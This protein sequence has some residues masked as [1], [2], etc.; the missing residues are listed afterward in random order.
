M[1]SNLLKASRDNES[2]CVILY[3]EVMKVLVLS[4][5]AYVVNVQTVRD[6]TPTNCDTEIMLQDVMLESEQ[7]HFM[8]LQCYFTDA[9]DA[10]NLLVAMSSLLLEKPDVRWPELNWFIDL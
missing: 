10:K 8:D 9:V 2:K 1:L 5:L 7:D 4:K 6:V 3:L